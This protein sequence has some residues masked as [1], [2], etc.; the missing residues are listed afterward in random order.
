MKKENEETRYKKRRENKGPT[1]RE[2]ERRT[3]EGVRRPVGDGHRFMVVHTMLKRT[4]KQ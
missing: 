4:K 2:S 3:K 1:R